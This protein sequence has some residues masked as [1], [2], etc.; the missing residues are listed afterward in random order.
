MI[1]EPPLLRIRPSFPRP[2]PEQVA[3]FQGVA[4]GL[5]C[6]A[7]LGRGVLDHRIKPLP[8]NLDTIVAGPVL[9]VECGPGDILALLASFKFIQAGDIVMSATDAYEGCAAAGDRVTGMLKNNGAAAFVT[10]GM[11]RD[12]V[13]IHDVGLPVWSAGVSPN[14]PFT[15]GPGTVGL[16]I[17]IGG[18]LIHP[19]DILVADRDGAVVVPLAEVDVVVE[20]LARVIEVENALDREIEQGLR[21]PEDI[22]TLLDSDKVAYLD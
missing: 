7:M 2:T 14:T 12:T 17:Q 21:L 10:D 13:G 5:V 16:P 11:V 4:T 22:A 20:R 15:T 19:G 8:A 3:A 18:Q 6:D 1:E 9:P